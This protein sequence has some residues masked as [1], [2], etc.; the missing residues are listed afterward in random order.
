MMMMGL[1][2]MGEAPFADV[3]IH[4]LV[5]DEHG[6]KM[7][8]SKG[9]VVD[10]LELIDQYGADA[11]RFAILASTAQG[12][13]IRFAEARVQGYRNFGTKLW[14]EARF[15]E[16]QQCDL[17]PAFDPT[18]CRHT[19]N[20]WAIGKLAQAAARA[21]DSLEAYRFNEAASVLYHFTWDE[22]C[23][24]YVELAKPLLASDD[25]AVQA[26]TRACA[27]WLLAQLLH[28][29]HPLTPFI[30]E[31]LW[32]R[33]YD[34]PGGPL[35][36]ASWPAVAEALVDADADAEIDWLIRAIGALRIARSELGLPPAT[37]LRLDVHDAAPET[38]ARL[39]R[40]RESLLRLARLSDVAAAEGTPA[41]GALQVVVDEATIVLPLAGAID[42]KDE[43]KRLDKELA[44]A[45][46]ELQRFDQKLANP[47]FLE[48]APAE[49]VDEQRARRAEAEQTRQK[50][51]A[52][53][54][55]FAS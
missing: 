37:K 32:Q 5:R 6:Q 51:E 29:L 17:D 30:T 41:E 13:D 52:A 18:S 39:Q 53:R 9:N 27:G 49:V 35:I 1:R 15:C 28:C 8:K 44:K 46:A 4:G 38:A 47:K 12:Q 2:F 25:T 22:F 40:H 24:W 54:A 3:C 19:V 16:L 23:D 34:A 50:L 33:R 42:L 14:N 43:R 45:V 31:E 48:R 36:A 26:E 55:R 20:R 11:L 10:P 7:S 21:R